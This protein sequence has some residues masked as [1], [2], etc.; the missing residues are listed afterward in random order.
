LLLAFLSCAFDPFLIIGY[1]L[2]ARG[3]PLP[4]GIE[5]PIAHGPWSMRLVELFMFHGYGTFFS[6]ETPLG[7]ALTAASF[8]LGIAGLAL[9]E[10]IAFL[11]KNPRAL[12]FA[13]L[14]SLV[15]LI[16]AFF[17]AMMAAFE[18]ATG[19]FV[20]MFTLCILLF[21]TA[22]S[23]TAA[24]QKSPTLQIQTKSKEPAEKPPWP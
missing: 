4:P 3:K 2:G 12:G 15:A 8:L 24:L 7:C 9:T 16:S 10:R 23:A 17:G 14:F 13:S 19:S 6:L 22:G 21:I 5:A 20:I 1:A 18:G 11:E